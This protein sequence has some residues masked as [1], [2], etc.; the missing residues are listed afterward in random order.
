MNSW[1]DTQRSA[2]LHQGPTSPLN[3]NSWV[4]TQ[5]NFCE[6]LLTI[7]PMNQQFGVKANLL[8][9]NYISFVSHFDT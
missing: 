3:Q 2:H 1:K 7:K 9:G 8:G 6:N 4:C 5:I